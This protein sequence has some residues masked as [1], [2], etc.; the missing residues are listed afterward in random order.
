LNDREQHAGE[1]GEKAGM[2]DTLDESEL[3]LEDVMERLQGL[4]SVIEDHHMQLLDN[5]LDTKEK[6]MEL[7]EEN[8]ILRE[9]IERVV[10]G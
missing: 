3:T 6:V 7:Q 5:V 10:D 8:R 4:R 2:T 1:A 9:L